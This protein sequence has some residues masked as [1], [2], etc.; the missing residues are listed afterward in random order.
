MTDS[1]IRAWLEKKLEEGIEPERL[2]K[3]LKHEGY[4]PKLIDEIQSEKTQSNEKEEEVIESPNKV[5]EKDHESEEDSKQSIKSSSNSSEIDLEDYGSKNDV[6][7]SEEKNSGFEEEAK[8]LKNIA[9][10]LKSDIKSG[11]KPGLEILAVFTVLVLGIG[12]VNTIDSPFSQLKQTIDF[13]TS[14]NTESQPVEQESG[15]EEINGTVVKFENGLANPS[16]PSV[17]PGQEVFFA[18]R[19]NYSLNLEFENGKESLDI[20]QGEVESTSF[21]SITYYSAVPDSEG[22]TEIKGSIYVR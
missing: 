6:S 14:Q 16:R 11:W 3:A 13:D 17:S 21:S 10:G 8:H 12:F 15:L 2:K 1:K 7:Y 18:N 4:D 20:P 19:E 22:E 5:S 9:G